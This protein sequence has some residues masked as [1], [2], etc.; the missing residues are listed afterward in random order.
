MRNRAGITERLPTGKDEAVCSNVTKTESRRRCG[1]GR[2]EWRP[3]DMFASSMET[4]RILRNSTEHLIYLKPVLPLI[5]SDMIT[6]S[7]EINTVNRVQGNISKRPGSWSSRLWRRP[8]TAE[9]AGSNPAGPITFLLFFFN[10]S[11]CI[12]NNHP[13]G[14]WFHS[15]LI[16][17][18][19][20]QKY[21]T[22]WISDKNNYFFAVTSWSW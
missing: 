18:D 9:V 13:S 22:H 2:G 6:D 20:V 17:F 21:W 12:R 19:V 1:F 14:R 4:S 7:P 11:C 15:L 5:R 16:T 3:E 10:W 8:Y